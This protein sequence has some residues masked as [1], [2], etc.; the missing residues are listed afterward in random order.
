MASGVAQATLLPVPVPGLQ[1]R[2]CGQPD[3]RQDADG[4]LRLRVPPQLE[5]AFGK[6]F[7]VKDVKFAYGQSEIDAAMS[8]RWAVTY[9]FLWRD[10]KKA[11]YV[12]A[13]VEH[14]LGAF[15]MHCY[16]LIAQR[17]GTMRHCRHPQEKWRWT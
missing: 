13:S 9:R 2:A 1:G 14:S 7:P 3:L 15:L 16:A 17:P 10:D 12:H 5:A 8:R 6:H 4:S 11:W